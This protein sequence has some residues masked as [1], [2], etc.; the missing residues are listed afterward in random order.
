MAQNSKHSE[1]NVE[2]GASITDKNTPQDGDYTLT[3]FL[4]EHWFPAIA[5]LLLTGAVFLTY[6]WNFNSGIS[7]QNT[8]WGT[9]GDFIGGTLNPIFGFISVILLFYA[10]TLQRKELKDTKNALKSQSKSAKTTTELQLL[11]AMLEFYEA[12]SKTAEEIKIKSITAIKYHEEEIK[13]ISNEV[14][15]ANKKINAITIKT[16]E[17]KN[18]TTDIKKQLKTQT[19]TK[20]KIKLSRHLI[21]TQ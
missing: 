4:K 3:I 2:Q 10:V 18:N 6:A 9:F 15:D 8:D 5:A 13:K 1:K 14:D 11:K 17:L 21:Q 7:S 12:E 19:T 16:N 20:K